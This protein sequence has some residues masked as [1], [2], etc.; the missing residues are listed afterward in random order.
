L[1]GVYKESGVPVTILFLPGEAEPI[2]LHELFFADELKRLLEKLPD[3][4]NNKK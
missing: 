3:K 1:S 4:Q 2:R